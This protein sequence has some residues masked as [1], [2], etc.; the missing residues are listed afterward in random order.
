MIV[1]TRSNAIYSSPRIEKYLNFYDN[2]NVNYL[3]VGWDRKGEN[4]ERKNTVYYKKKGGYNVGGFHAVAN[5]LGWMF[6]LFKILLKNKKSITAI[7]ACDLDTAFPAT[8]FKKILKKEVKVIFDVCD[9]FSATLSNQNKFVLKVFIWM[10]KYTTKHTDEVIICEP[11][12]IE[13]I[14]FVLKK[15]E[16]ILPNIPTFEDTNFL[17]KN[18]EYKFH[19]NNITFSYVGGFGKERFIDELLD[20]AERKYINLLI[21]GYGDVEIE[22][23][24]EI[25]SNTSNV[26]YFGKVEYKK[27]LNIMYNSDVI[28][29]MYC[30]SNPNNIYAAPNKFYESMML[31]RPILSTK[32]ISISHKIEKYNIGY[33]IDESTDDLIYLIESLSKKDLF[34]KGENASLLWRDSFQFY[35]ADFLNHTY[36]NLLNI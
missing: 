14:P 32:G 22:K 34:Q 1:A 12:R 4:L 29:A 18:E 13:Q 11:E 17:N 28:Y 16:L 24:C 10:E 33:I 7:H 6:F 15:K 3:V 20:V 23:R 19:N 8:I 35:T 2:N 5:R 30:K 25:L 31:G 21:A 26:K 36:R 27:G 9:W